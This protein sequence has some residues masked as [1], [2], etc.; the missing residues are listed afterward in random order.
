MTAGV[1]VLLSST[2]ARTGV[3]RLSSVLGLSHRYYTGPY[4]P[5]LA[6]RPGAPY[7]D[8]KLRTPAPG[9]HCQVGQPRIAPARDRTGIMA[10]FPKVRVIA[11][12]PGLVPYCTVGPGPG[13]GGGLA[14]DQP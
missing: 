8:C 9:A 11:T 10:Y 5:A 12:G 1:T 4:Y 7:G 3:G 6:N 13:G 14:A 2:A